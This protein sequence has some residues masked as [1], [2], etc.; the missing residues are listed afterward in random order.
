MLTP[1]S[2]ARRNVA[3]RI[4]Q[5]LRVQ[6]QMPAPDLTGWQTDQVLAAIE[7]METGQFADGE[8]AMMKAEWPDLWE[9]AGYAPVD[10]MGAAQ[11][12]ERLTR[13]LTELD[14]RGYRAPGFLVRGIGTESRGARSASDPSLGTRAGADVMTVC[15]ELQRLA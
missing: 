15:A 11:L 9:P 7:A 4:E 3:W 12:L 8:R 13:V 10:S 2:T 14:E 1:I 5:F 6:E